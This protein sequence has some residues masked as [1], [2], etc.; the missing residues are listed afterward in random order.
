MVEDEPMAEQPNDEEEAPAPA[1]LS[2]KRRRQKDKKKRS[3]D[4][5]EKAKKAKE[6]KEKGGGGAKISGT[7]KPKKDKNAPKGAQSAYVLWCVPRSRMPTPSMD[8]ARGMPQR[9]R[10]RGGRSKE[11]RKQE[12]FDT[13]GFADAAKALGAAWRALEEVLRRE[14]S[15]MTAEA[16]RI[17]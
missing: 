9:R 15:M 13:L 16:S 14:G 3:A 12:P 1:E 7:K 6:K 8:E 5:T 10:A 11:A 17:S 4:G 2:D